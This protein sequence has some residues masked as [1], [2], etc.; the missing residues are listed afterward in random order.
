M[1]ETPMQG[2]RVFS[3]SNL[4]EGDVTY[5][6]TYLSSVPGQY[7]VLWDDIQ[8]V[9][10]N[11]QYVRNGTAAVS[12]L[13]DTDMIE[14]VGYLVSHMDIRLAFEFAPR[15]I[16][17]HPGIDLMVVLE[18]NQKDNYK[19]DDTLDSRN[20]SSERTTDAKSNFLL[21]AGFEVKLENDSG[22]KS[23]PE[24]KTTKGSKTSKEENVGLS[25]AV[26]VLKVTAV[27]AV[28]TVSVIAA[29][30]L[31]PSAPFML[32]GA[33]VFAEKHLHSH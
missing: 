7:F 22:S 19:A 20:V 30:A 11:A 32:K 33:Q 26:K 17:H 28:C 12:F 15:R 21:K 14:Y 18:N 4:S 2:F 5:I 23:G 8:H 13:R 1:N 29:P 9:F 16:A 24:S 27:L 25:V 31:L 6:G 3:D 10:R